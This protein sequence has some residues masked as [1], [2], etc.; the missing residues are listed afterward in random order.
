[1]PG[2][3]SE[4]D[5]INDMTLPTAHKIAIISKGSFNGEEGGGGC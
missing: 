1:M 2:K 4:D 5:E 3:P